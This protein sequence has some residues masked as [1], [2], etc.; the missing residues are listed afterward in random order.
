MFAVYATR[1]VNAG[2]GTDFQPPSSTSATVVFNPGDDREVATVIIN[3][4]DIT[5]GPE[6][7]E[8]SIGSPSIGTVESQYK[9]TVTIQDI[10]TTSKLLS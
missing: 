8:V 1:P 2:S 10:A 6:T 7:F 5:E 4:D 9:A 3:S